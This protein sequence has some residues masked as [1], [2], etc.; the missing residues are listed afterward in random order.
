MCE[1]LKVAVTNMKGGVL[2]TTIAAT[3]AEW[4]RLHGR[5]VTV[6][7]V[8]HQNDLCKLMNWPTGPQMVEFLDHT[9]ELPEDALHYTDRPGLCYVPGNEDLLG[10]GETFTMRLRSKATPED[11]LKLLETLSNRIYSLGN[12]SDV[13]FVDAPKSGALQQAPV[14]GADLLIIPFHFDYPTIIDTL[15]MVNLAHG[16]MAP[17]AR[18]VLVPVGFRMKVNKATLPDKKTVRAT[19]D[20]HPALYADQVEI[21]PDYTADQTEALADLMANCAEIDRSITLADGIVATRS[22]GTITFK[23]KTIFEAQPYGAIAASYANFCTKTF[24]S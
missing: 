12:S 24:V 18:I 10:F 13:I 8:D 20:W 4:L 16:L 22:A 17:A 11:A 21:A 1:N 23:G 15:G 5:Y 14:M 7:G 2:A 9:I 19:P 3:V 6:V